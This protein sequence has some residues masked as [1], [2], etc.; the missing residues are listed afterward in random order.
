MVE[1]VLPG[2][3]RLRPFVEGTTNARARNMRLRRAEARGLLPARRYLSASRFAYVASEL[4]AALANLPTQHAAT[5][6]AH[7]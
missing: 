4:E 1:F 6:P 2:D 5:R 3:A 7:G